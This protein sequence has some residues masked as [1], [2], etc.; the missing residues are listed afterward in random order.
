MNRRIFLAAPAIVMAAVLF[1]NNALANSTRIVGGSNASTGAYPWMAA[2][3]SAGSGSAYDA[4]FCGG[5]LIAPGWVLTA[6]H[7]VEGERASG[8]AVVIG[9]TRLDT[10]TGERIGV[11][12]IIAHPD[13]NS[14]GVP[15]IALL[16]LS[17]NSTRTPVGLVQPGSNAANA[18]TTARVIGWGATSEDGPGTPRLQE[19]SIP[20]VSHSACQRTYGNIDESLEICA[21]LSQGGRDSCQGDS[22]GPLFVSGSDGN[23]YLQAGVVSWGEGCAQPNFP[24][25]YAR[26][27]SIIGWIEQQ[28][29][30]TGSGTGGSTGGGTG[31]GTDG[32]SGGTDGETEE[33]TNG[34]L[35]ARFTVSCDSLTCSFDGSASTAGDSRIEDYVWDL[36]DGGYEYGRRFEYTYDRAGTYEITLWV[37]DEYGDYVESVQDIVVSNS[38][39]PTN[40]QNGS[41]EFEKTRWDDSI[42]SG[43][44]K[45]FPDRRGMQVNA[46]RLKVIL[47]HAIE[48]DFD[49]RVQQYDANSGSW[50][51]LEVSATGGKKERIVIDNASAGTYR[52]MAVSRRGGGNLRMIVRHY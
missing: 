6:A 1:S 17:S 12:Q 16:K 7:C 45:V 19:V 25:V 22:G 38:S 23:R 8:M 11:S 39:T 52:F 29:G 5:S 10:D 42:N 37:I 31:G 20:I 33:P 2:L 21:G 51:T 47:K 13:Y 34:V 50:E 24:G 9:A 36:G 49:L 32:G 46:G 48:N 14:T 4:Q 44:R 15:D 26:V 41:G 30:S 35:A 28:T 18:G 43:S 3:I 27:S 40:P